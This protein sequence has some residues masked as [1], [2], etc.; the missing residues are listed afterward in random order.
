MFGKQLAR[1]QFATWLKETH[2]ALFQSALRYAENW[3]EKTAAAQGRPAAISGLGETPTGA[4]QEQ[5]FWQKFVE[6]MTGLAT[7]VLAYKGQKEV[8][9]ANIRLAEMGQPPID[10]SAGAPTVRTTVDLSPE[11]LARFQDAGFTTEN[12]IKW[13]ALGLG[14]FLLIPKLIGKRGRR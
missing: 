5:T 3:R 11:V 8:L 6:G 4:V 10:V 12:L 1:A 7:G 14:A 9:E 13:G 2:P